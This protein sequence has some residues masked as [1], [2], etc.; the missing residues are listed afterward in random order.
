MRAVVQR[1]RSASV[2]VDDTLISS[3]NRGLLVLLGVEAGDT[4]KDA[5]QMAS[6]I[7]KLRIFPSP[8][9]A[10]V[11]G[12]SSTPAEG[13]TQLSKQ[14]DKSVVAIDGEILCISQFT[15]LASVKKNKPSFHRAEGPQAALEMYDYTMAQM[16]KQFGEAS[17]GKVKP[18]VFGAYMQ[19]SLV[20]D[21]P[22]T[23]ELST[24]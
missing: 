18:G 23:I 21:G 16:E 5:E 12:S 3:I 2:S 9:A 1:V 13:S 20:N 14:W 10:A 17:V 4:Q 7:T 8:P 11:E 15:L 19:V 24:K 6:Q 22:V